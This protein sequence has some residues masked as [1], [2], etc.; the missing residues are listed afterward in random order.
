M[1]PHAPKRACDGCHRRK[2][3][4][5][6]DNPCQNC[7][8]A[9][10]ACTYHSVPQKKGPK[11][12]RAKVISEIRDIQRGN[13][14]HTRVSNIMRGAPNPLD[15]PDFS[16]SLGLVTG[17]F[18][19]EC[20]AYL[21]RNMMDLV[22]FV[23]VSMLESHIKDMEQRPG[24]Y[25][26]LT[27]LA[28]YTLVQPGAPIPHPAGDGHMMDGLPMVTVIGSEILADEAI[29]VRKRHDV[30][31]APDGLPSVMSIMTSF[32]LYAHFDMKEIHAKAWNHLREMTTLMCLAGMDRES[33][34]DKWPE[35]EAELRRRLFWV[36]YMAERKYAI[37][38]RRP[39]TLAARDMN[40]PSESHIRNDA[41]ADGI[42]DFVNK[43]A[44]VR[45][46]DEYSHL[47]KWADVYHE[48]SSA[49][50]NNELAML[51]D[52]VVNNLSAR[53]R[54]FEGPLSIKA[55]LHDASWTFKASA[56]SGGS[57]DEN[58]CRLARE[59]TMA[60]ASAF[61]TKLG[62]ADS[63]LIPKL[64]DMASLVIDYLE[65]KSQASPFGPCVRT[66]QFLTSIV[67]AVSQND[68]RCVPLLFKEVSNTLISA[69]DVLL[70]EMP[71]NAVQVDIFDG[72]GNAGMAQGVV[73]QFALPNDYQELLKFES[74]GL[75]GLTGRAPPS[76][77]NLGP[78]QAPH[79][80]APALASPLGITPTQGFPREPGFDAMMGH[81]NGGGGGS[82]DSAGGASLPCAQDG[83]WMAKASPESSTAFGFLGGGGSVNHHSSPVAEGSTRHMSPH[84]SPPR[85]DMS[86]S[87]SPSM[88]STHNAA[89]HEMNGAMNFGHPRPHPT[90]RQNSAASI[91]DS[92]SYVDMPGVQY[93][94]NVGGNMMDASNGSGMMDRSSNGGNMITNNT[95]AAMSLH[96]PLQTASPVAQT[97]FQ[98]PHMAT[99]MKDVQGGVQAA[100]AGPA[101][102][103]YMAMP[104]QPSFDFSIS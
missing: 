2:V 63:G 51:M 36:A 49:N 94:H 40:P 95:A 25:C 77:L 39:I 9:S 76:A 27:A 47:C 19:R 13:N 26:M 33:S 42:H 83:K 88:H 53:D 72:F 54:G 21:A 58:L 66:P 79:H 37:R 20:I 5:N 16:P 45:E 104:T 35:A 1:P 61:P 57:G 67:G 52:E 30:F 91:M 41:A 97:Q 31:G 10:I 32:F 14:I 59:T 100:L 43:V 81:I 50:G 99:G 93:T 102:A 65:A 64:A 6:G 86:D 34:Y 98:M 7:G 15:P 82:G 74:M 17:G 28:A 68:Y 24:A 80:Y 60:W 22:P 73:P 78:Q 62:V 103:G 89:A 71:V 69:A 8:A 3:K 101:Y 29:R 96:A 11:G 4:C 56:R 38:Y 85:Y 87:R 55:F 92:L 48:I 84:V 46:L 23:D 18:V 70:H 12:S 44:M 90:P 75:A